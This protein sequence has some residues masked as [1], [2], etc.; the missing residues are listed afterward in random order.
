METVHIFT[1]F[2]KIQTKWG[3]FKHSIHYEFININ[4]RIIS[5]ESCNHED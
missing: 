5:E 4:I 2:H 3:S 1:L